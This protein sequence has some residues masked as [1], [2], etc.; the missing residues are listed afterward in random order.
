MNA[1]G[2]YGFMAGWSPKR[3]NSESLTQ[4][5]A[6]KLQDGGIMCCFWCHAETKHLP[7]LVLEPMK[8]VHALV[9][10]GGPIFSV[11]FLGGP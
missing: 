1:Q 10:K 9:L 2:T 7:R 4:V 11:L 8:E 3:L 5:A 6:D